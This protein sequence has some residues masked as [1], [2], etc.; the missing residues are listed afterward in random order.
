MARYRVGFGTPSAGRSGPWMAAMER[1]PVTTQSQGAT[2]FRQSRPLR[3]STSRAT[4]GSSPISHRPA[5]ASS[6]PPTRWSSSVPSRSWSTPA[7]RCTVSTGSTRSSPSWS[8]RTFGGCSCPTM[9]VITWETSTSCSSAVPTPPSWPTSSSTSARPWS[10]PCRS[11]ACG[12]WARESP[13]RPATVTCTCW[14][15]P[16]PFR[17]A[18]DARPLRRQDRRAVGGRLLRRPHTR[19]GARRR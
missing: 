12:G 7:H 14:A 11:I 13:S 10:D 2:C 4:R 16:A 5:P 8:R 18:H 9:T 19:R 3:L 1:S 17:R 6:C 15:G